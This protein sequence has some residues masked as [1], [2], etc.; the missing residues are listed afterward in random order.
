MTLSPDHSIGVASSSKRNFSQYSVQSRR[1]TVQIAEPCCFLDTVDTFP[2]PFATLERRGHYFPECKL[3]FSVTL[4][5]GFLIPFGC[6]CE[7]LAFVA[8]T[9]PARPIA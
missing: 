1:R 7:A 4:L 2:R 3:R 9:S 8:D 6:V 5:S